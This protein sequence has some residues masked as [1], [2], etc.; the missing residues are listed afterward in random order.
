MI[1]KSSIT[2]ALR[3]IPSAHQ[4]Q[5]TDYWASDTVGLPFLKHWLLGEWYRRST[6]IKALITEFS[7]PSAHQHQTLIIERVIHR[8]ISTRTLITERVIPSV[9]QHQSTVCWASDTV[10]PPA[11]KQCLLS[12]WYRRSTSTKAPI[13]DGLPT[14][15][16]WILSEWY[17]RSISI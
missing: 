5:S 12:E 17:R 10:G 11:L 4:H 1:L 2:N 13:S 14:A 6:S 9:Y 15:K 3:V 8:S 16:H 7:I